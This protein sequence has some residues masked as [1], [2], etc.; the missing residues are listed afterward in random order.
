MKEQQQSFASIRESQGAEA[1]SLAL[2]VAELLSES[3]P[4]S[5]TVVL[6]ISDRS[7]FADFF[8]I[9]SGE[10]ER[11]LRAIA[12]NVEDQLSDEGRLPRRTEGDPISGWMVLDYGDV[13]IH[14]F[15][16]DQR[17]FYRLEE[18]WSDSVPVLAIQ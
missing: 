17:A 16:A 3:T 14:V 11:Q 4:A 15:E 8:V 13:V 6:D 1:R 9:C 12:N 5:D 7:S 2:H 18:L 10:N